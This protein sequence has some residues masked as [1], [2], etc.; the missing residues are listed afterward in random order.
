MRRGSQPRQ[1]GLP[2][3]SFQG[4][5]TFLSTYNSTYSPENLTALWVGR[6]WKW[7][8]IF[9][10]RCA[11]D[12]CRHVVILRYNSYP[13]WHGKPPICCYYRPH[14]LPTRADLPIDWCAYNF[15]S[16]HDDA[17]TNS[18]SETP[19]NSVLGSRCAVSNDGQ[20]IFRC[21]IG[22]LWFPESVWVR[23]STIAVHVV[24]C[25]NCAPGC[26]VVVVAAVVVIHQ[27]YVPSAIS[28]GAEFAGCWP[29]SQLKSQTAPGLRLLI[30]HVNR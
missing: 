29:S 8:H 11:R 21:A 15:R 25:A 18:S 20:N 5:F 26:F 12:G 3:P 10:C 22:D 23:S 28:N 2:L 24:Y 13:Y 7:P 27:Q 19:C 17:H 4:T 30:G 6:S 1:M 14:S 16:G 9:S